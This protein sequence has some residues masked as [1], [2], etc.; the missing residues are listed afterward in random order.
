[1]IVHFSDAEKTELRIEPVRRRDGNVCSMVLNGT[2][3]RESVK[4]GFNKLKKTINRI[5][6]II[7]FIVFF[8]L[9]SNELK[10]LLVDAVSCHLVSINT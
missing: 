7:R 9:Y 1:M 8:F 3:V 2:A 10:L 5:M 6:K 4:S